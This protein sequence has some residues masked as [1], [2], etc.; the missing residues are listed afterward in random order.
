VEQKIFILKYCKK[1]G[2]KVKNR[3]TGTHGSDLGQSRGNSFILDLPRLYSEVC[4]KGRPSTLA[5][6]LKQKVV[7]LSQFSKLPTV[8]S[9]K[10]LPT[11][12]AGFGS[13][14]TNMNNGIST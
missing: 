7:L 9:N 6:K 3:P 10:N 5:E 8:L 12:F 4:L 2:K 13:I 14:T 1:K 11:N